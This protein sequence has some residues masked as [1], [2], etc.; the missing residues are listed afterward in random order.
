[1]AR[2][3]MRRSRVVAAVALGS[4]AALLAPSALRAFV[5]GM[6]GRSALRGSMRTATAAMPYI[7][8]PMMNPLPW[9]HD[10]EGKDA[11]MHT[12]CLTAVDECVDSIQAFDEGL[13]AGLTE[14]QLHEYDEKLAA[15]VRQLEDM[16]AKTQAEIAGHASQAPQRRESQ[17]IWL[18]SVLQSVGDLRRQL[19]RIRDLEGKLHV[20]MAQKDRGF[21]QN[22][23]RAC[24]VA[25]GG[26]KGVVKGDY[27]ASGVQSFSGLQ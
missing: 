5:A 6:P 19:Q 2:S 17:R 20:R 21:L 24:A 9:S 18:D 14:G 26:H 13:E 15:G 23:I 16:I 4:A 10:L 1:M 8:P 22:L 27:P 25:I 11:Q 12:D 7:A 3:S